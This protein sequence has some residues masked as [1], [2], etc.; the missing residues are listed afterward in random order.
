MGQCPDPALAALQQ[1]RWEQAYALLSERAATGPADPDEL[2]Q[3]GTA[4]YMTGRDEE[5]FACWEQ[6]H[7][8][9]LEGGDVAR[10]A[11]LGVQVAQALSFKGDLAR[12]GG[13]VERVRRLLDACGT[14]AVERGYLEHAAGTCRILQDG[15]AAG[16]RDCFS[17]A[18]R[19]ADRYGDPALRTLAQIGL[20]RCLIYLGEVAR[21]V[22][23]L[24]EAMV[25][26]AASEV[27][28]VVVGDAYCTVID[29]CHE[30]FD[31]RR[32]E[33]WTNAF[34]QWCDS[35]HGLVLYR[36]HCLLHRAEVLQLHG[37]WDE[38]V[39]AAEDACRR[40]AEPLNPLT[41][42]GAHYVRAELHR[43]RAELPEAER[44]YGLA[45]GAGG[46][47]QPGLSL[48]RLAQ[49][50]TDLAEAGIRRALAQAEG[51]VQRARVLGAYAEIVL[52]AGDVRAAQDAAHELAEVGER[53]RSAWLLGQAAQLT[54]AVLLARGDPAA[55]L[56]PLGRAL[57]GWTEL[58]APYDACRTRLL[59]ATACAALGDGDGA[60]LE[61]AAARAGFAQLGAAGDLARLAPAPRPPQQRVPGGLTARETEV[62][63]LVARGR[64]NREIAR[65]LFISEKTVTSHLTHVFTKLGL[66]SRTAAA[67]FAYE[68]HL[69]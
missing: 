40:L 69:V 7:R 21:G 1:C 19:L 31:T 34:S 12:S 37:R 10:G 17:R 29:A 52:A 2:D 65:E 26:M 64:S 48:L 60:E 13:W 5:A 39:T 51:P 35:Q 57:R 50:R 15:D 4:A 22:A 30:L 25:S 63:V 9:A 46:E 28:P 42:G 32:C 41:L 67:A 14:E 59:I 23:L 62:L 68:H 24:D 56:V 3:L 58:D 47:P 36:G 11:R 6:G 38:A 61:R 53:L 44:C 55:S 33:S 45:H 27:P 43:L 18:M 16:A 20:G 8:T 49:G 66:A 54:G